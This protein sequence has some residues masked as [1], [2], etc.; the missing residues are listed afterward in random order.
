MTCHSCVK[1]IQDV[2]GAR[3]GIYSI[4]V[5]LKEENGKIKFDSGKWTGEQVAE[6]IDDMGFECKVINGEVRISGSFSFE[7]CR[8]SL[9]NANRTVLFAARYCARQFEM[10]NLSSS[11]EL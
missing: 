6:A 11:L 5:N 10:L 1:N 8:K 2:I 4:R 9:K 7:N 3:D